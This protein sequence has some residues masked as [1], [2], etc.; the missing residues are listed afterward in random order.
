MCIHAHYRHKTV[1]SYNFKHLI[2]NLL[3]QM[4]FFFLDEPFYDYKILKKLLVKSGLWLKKD[5][6]K[7]A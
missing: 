3:S 1:H 4:N 5:M 7:V 2:Y 6:G